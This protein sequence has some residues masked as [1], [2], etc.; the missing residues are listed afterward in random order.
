MMSALGSPRTFRA[1]GASVSWTVGGARTLV[2]GVLN[3]TPDSF[4]AGSRVSDHQQAFDAG[5]ALIDAGA[6]LL[7]LGGESTRPGAASVAAADEMERVLPVLERLAAVSPVPISIDTMKASVARAAVE[8]GACLVNDVSGGLADS[9]MA[10]EISSL[11]VPVVVGHIRGTPSD[12]QNAP[13]YEDP[14]SEISRSLSARVAEFVEAGV[15][16]SDILIDPG[17]GFGKRTCDNVHILDRL[18]EFAE[19]GFPVVIGLSRKRF[20]GEFLSD[21]GLVDEGPEDRLEAS[22]AAAV[23]A[24]ARGA[25]VVRVHDVAETRRALSLVDGMRQVVGS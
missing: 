1:P 22:V 14:V 25:S 2:M 7:D 20:L 23:L 11:A 19:L 16:R 4:Y 15:P 9:T 18:D 13:Q 5:M 12:M 6:D 8:A 21:A 3:L 17:I 24:A 10:A